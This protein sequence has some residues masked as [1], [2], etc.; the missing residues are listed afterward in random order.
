MPTL[1]L[2]SPPTTQAVLLN[3][4]KAHLRVD[5]TDDDALIAALISAATDAL[6]YLNRTIVPCQWELDLP[7]F[8][9]E[10]ILP[11]PP[12]IAV[13]SVIYRDPANVQQTLPA[14]VY[15]VVTDS[16][17]F[18]Y[19]RLAYGQSWPDVRSGGEPVTIRYDAG[20]DAPPPP[21]KAAIMLRVARLYELR[22]AASL[23]PRLRAETNE[24]INRFEYAV[25]SAGASEAVS[26]AED[27]LLFRYL[28]RSP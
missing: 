26:E 11:R 20:Y 12:L 6:Y 10:I 24:G 23:A 16:E 3:E 8:S 27:H 2:A 14:S 17:G 5:T 22:D 18:G 7:S 1:R 4:A 15:D 21:I 25:S 28:A 13:S 9:D 19:V